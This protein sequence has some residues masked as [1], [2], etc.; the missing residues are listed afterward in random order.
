VRKIITIL[1]LLTIQYAYGQSLYFHHLT[2][3][4]GLSDNNTRCVAVDKNGFL[5][6][7]TANGLNAYNGYTVTRYFKQ[8]QP[9]LCSNNIVVLLCDDRNRIWAGS[10]SGITMIDEN[11][12]F[13]MVSFIDSIGTNFNC[14]GIMQTEAGNIVAFTNIGTYQLDQN[15]NQWSFLKAA[16][17]ET[18]K[19][20]LRDYSKLKNDLFIQTGKDELIVFD[21]ATQKK[22]FDFMLPFSITACRYN[23]DEI[24]AAS[25]KGRLSRISI[26]QNKIVKE[27]PL[28]YNAGGKIVNS[29]ISSIRQ[30]PNGEIVIAGTGGCFVFDPIKETISP[31]THDP[32]QDGS[33]AAGLMDKIF[34]FPRGNVFIT[35]SDQG[36]SYFN[37][38]EYKAAHKPAFFGENNEIYDSYVNDIKKDSKG[39]FWLAGRDCFL[40]WDK[41]ARGSSIYRYYFRMLDIGDRPLAINVIYFDRKGQ[42]WIGTQ[43]GGL[44]LFNENTKS[45]KQFSQ[46]SSK[47]KP[48]FVNNFIYDIMPSC[49]DSVWLATNAGVVTF[50]INDHKWDTLRNSPALRTLHNK[51]ILKYF[52]S[53]NGH[54][55]I[56]TF[57]VGLYDYDPAKGSIKKYSVVGTQPG[58]SYYSFAEDDS[59]NIYMA[60]RNGFAVINKNSNFTHYNTT[61]GLRYQECQSVIINK[62]KEIWISNSNCLAKFDPVKKSFQF[63]DEK[64]GLTDVGFRP[65][66]S[67]EDEDGEQYWGTVK[68]LNYF[69]PSKMRPD[70]AG[71]IPVIYQADLPDT[72]IY[73]G[74]SNSIELSYNKN[75]VTFSFAAISLYNETNILYEYRLD[76][77][78]NR[79]IKTS[80]GRQVRY[81]SLQPGKYTFRVRDSRDGV[82]WTEALNQIKVRVYPAFWQTWWFITAVILVLAIVGYWLFRMR[83]SKI[84]EREQL[85]GSYEKKI[86]AVEMGSLRAQ[87]NPHF[88]FNSL[89]SINNFI[90]KNDPD[91]ASGYLTKFSRLMRLILD[92]SRNEWVTLENELRALELYIEMEALRFDNAFDHRIEIT[93][94]VNPEA[95]QIPPMIIQPYVENAI[96]HGLLHRKEPGGKLDIHIWKN[97]NMLNIE[98]EDN[99]IGR[100]EAKRKKSK[101]ATRQKSYGMEITTQ[102]LEIVNRLYDVHA[103]VAIKDLVNTDGKPEGTVI[104]LNIMYKELH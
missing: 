59:G 78:D 33:I 64:S 63:F 22:V 73:L 36:L 21:Y 97:N 57:N 79:W 87:M 75:V 10:A 18:K 83:I 16:S 69:Q 42:N 29:S 94:D 44:G 40:I 4:N 12:Q 104:L 102:R 92:N 17:A 5:W 11:R 86:A 65:H 85:K 43:G 14:N 53:S 51:I 28:T 23:D 76:G 80:G 38:L 101:T 27:Y 66:A 67:F 24:L 98:I 32:L 26:S 15:S 25:Y 61:N 82:N 68:G 3:A 91:N 34:A 71:I 45:F 55:W 72:S 100:E 41:T 60:G 7:G 93:E 74:A 52:K 19:I 58:S 2:T 20:G 90:L 6:I 49:K 48:N 37:I 96:W 95:V 62:R 77:L 89:N 103:T 70:T 99:G 39:R 84:K 50:N 1:S 8:Q 47:G 9:N 31:Y 81:N 35:S 54:I 13:H 56:S 46:D 88:I 30:A